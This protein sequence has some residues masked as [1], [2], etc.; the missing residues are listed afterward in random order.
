MVNEIKKHDFVLDG[1]SPRDARIRL[2]PMTD[3]D[4]KLLYQWNNDPEVLYYAEGDDIN[5][6][7]LDEIKQL[8][9]SVCSQ[10]YC[11]IIEA[12]GVPIGECW[13]QEMNLPRVLEKYPQLDVR[14]IDLL[15]GEKEWWNQGIGTTVIRLLTEFGFRQVNAD[16]IYEPD[17]ADYNLRSRKAFQKAGFET[18]GMQTAEP[19][20][21][22]KYWF[23]LA[24][25]R[26]QFL[27]MK[28]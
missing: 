7:S 3:A 2:R 23:D 24:L 14:R 18:V 17:V 11:F 20:D 25:T 4:L 22:A 6:Y 9:S 15:I 12:D 16:L 28:T 5:A 13:L 10:A 26:D 1:I 8:Y 19:G 27:A 21:K